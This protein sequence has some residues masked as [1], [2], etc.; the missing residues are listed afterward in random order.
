[1]NQDISVLSTFSDLVK[2]DEL[3]QKAF[4]LNLGGIIEEKLNESK[5][6]YHHPADHFHLIDEYSHAINNYQMEIQSL[7]LQLFDRDQD[8][9]RLNAEVADKNLQLKDNQFQIHAAMDGLRRQM[10]GF[11]TEFFQTKSL[12]CSPSEIQNEYDVE[13]LS[14]VVPLSLLLSCLPD[15]PIS[16]RVRNLFVQKWN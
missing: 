4:M 5:G 10:E 12:P 11:K 7:K 6:E 3:S 2:R 16:S 14:K 1:L 8:L 15:L 13:S 9:E